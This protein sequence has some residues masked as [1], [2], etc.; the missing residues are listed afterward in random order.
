MKFLWAM[1]LLCFP[2]RELLPNDA[3]PQ[4]PVERISA[5]DYKKPYHMDFYAGF[6]SLYFSE[7][8]D[9]LQ[10]AGI[11]IGSIEMGYKFIYMGAWYANSPK[12]PYQEGQLGFGITHFF[13]EWKAYLG[14]TFLWMSANPLQ[15]YEIQSGVHGSNLFYNISLDADIY[16]SFFSQGAY[17]LLS[18]HLLWDW[19]WQ[20]TWTVTVFSGQNYHYVPDA[21][22]GLDSIGSRLEMERSITE[23][24]SWLIHITNSFAIHKNTAK[25][26]DLPLRNLV[27]VGLGMIYS[28]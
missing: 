13:N 2:F 1:I 16:Y 26:G 23:H 19:F 10:N 18:A 17:L 11:G 6:D 28:L 4:F 20:T 24:F 9:N 21:H 27:Y 14:T 7:G 22:T 15:D 8:R 25:P 3:E 12:K 5:H